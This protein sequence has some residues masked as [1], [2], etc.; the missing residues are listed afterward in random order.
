MVDV[1]GT[2]SRRKDIPGKMQEPKHRISPRKVKKGI[3]RVNWNG[4]RWGGAEEWKGVGERKIDSRG[5]STRRMGGA[6][7]LIRAKCIEE[8]KAQ[9]ASVGQASR[10]ME[11]RKV[12]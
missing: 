6:D 3:A 4:R 2:R 10:M 9:N 12:K 5:R 7:E 8:R 11:R 1:G